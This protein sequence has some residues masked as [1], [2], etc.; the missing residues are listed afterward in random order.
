M[1]KAERGQEDG[2]LGYNRKSGLKF[3]KNSK[4]ILGRECKKTK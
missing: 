3:A 1:E 2:K 4:W